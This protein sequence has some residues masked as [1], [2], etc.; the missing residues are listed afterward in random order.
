MLTTLIKKP[1]DNKGGGCYT[2]PVFPLNRFSK[3]FVESSGNF[4]ATQLGVLETTSSQFMGVGYG[5]KKEGMQMSLRNIASGRK[6]PTAGADSS[7]FS[8][9]AYLMVFAMLGF[10]PR[11][12]MAQ[13]Y[14]ALLTGVVTDPSGAVV[15]QAEVAL[16]DVSK[17][18]TITTKSDEGGRYVFAYLPP[19]G[20]RLTVKAPGFK[21]FVRE[22]IVLQVQERATIEVHLEVGAATETVEVVAA[23]ASLSLQDATTGQEVNRVFINDLPLLGRSVY[24][25]A[26]LAPGVTDVVQPYHGGTG[27]AINFISNGS[28]NSTADVLL[29]GVSTTGN[30]QSTGAQSALYTPSVDAV[31][32]FKVQQSNFSADIG[33]SGAT[34]INMLMRSGTNQFHGSAYEY[35]RN[36]VLTGNDWFRNANNV[37]I[38]ARRYNLFGF[39]IGGPIRKDRTFFF[40]DYEGKRDLA[41]KTFRAGVPSAAMRTGDFAEICGAGF[42]ANGMCLDEE[43]QLWDPYSGVYDPDEGGPVR[44]LPIPYNNL[45]TYQSPGNPN[46]DGT[47]YQLAPQPG[48]LIDPVASRMM[49]GYPLPNIGVGSADY[50]RFNN[51]IGS[52]SSRYS[53]NQWDL[54][55]D[56]SFRAQDRLSA[57]YSELRNKGL[58]AKCWDNATD[59]CSGGHEYDTTRMFSLNFTHTFNST[60]LLS[61][62]LGIARTFNFV[63]S[64]VEDYPPEDTDVVALRMPEYTLRSGVRALPNIWPADYG[65]AGPVGCLGTQA[66]SVFRNGQETHHL[67]AS[68]VR[69]QGRHELKIGGEGRMHRINLLIPEGGA[70]VYSYYFNSTSQYPWWGGGDAM[71]SFLTGV[72]TPGSWG[73]YQVPVIPATQNF[74]YAGYFQDNWKVTKRLTLNLGMRYDLETSRTERHNRGSYFDPEVSSPLQVPGLTGLRGGLRFADNQ[75]RTIYDNDRNNWGPRFGLAYRLADNLVFRGGYGLFYSISRRGT[76]GPDSIGWQ[77][78]KETSDWITSFQGDGATPWGRLSDPW[79]VTGPSLPPGSSEGLLSYVGRGITAP[80]RTIVATPYEQTWS[81]GIQQSLPGNILIDANYVGKKGTKL[82]FSGAGGL[83]HLGPELTSLP[84]DEISALNEYV[85][86][87]FFGII[88]NPLSPL[89]GPT[90][91]AYQLQLPFPQFTGVSADSPPVAN[92]IYHAFQLRVERRFAKGFQL[93]ATYSNG[94]SIDDS[95]VASGDVV[96]LGGGRTSLQDPNRRFLERSLSFFDIS[97]ILQLAYV[98][99]LPIGRGKAVGT[100]WNPWLNGFLGGWKTN[101]IWRF[102]SG[103]P[104]SLTLSGGQNLPTYGDQRPNLTAPLRRSTGADFVDQYFANP[105]VAVVPPPF[106][107]GLA[108]RTIS[109]VRAPG[110]NMATLSLFKEIPL[111]GVREGMR[112]EYRVEAFNAFNRPHFCGPDDVVEGGSFG[113]ITSICQTPREFQ[114][115]LKLYW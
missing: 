86:N 7:Y 115:A 6:C 50:D 5:I 39:T 84:L 89:S 104:I 11:T 27:G 79:P 13:L 63:P 73:E 97:Q 90:V 92:S 43:G 41:A 85:P 17:G 52:G 98:Y 70:G 114:M 48:N 4:P 80:I 10:S 21:S 103:P 55:I 14:S 30:E 65:C 93:L 15:P 54:K 3:H 44:S 53:T 61:V 78:Y 16:V 19:S 45:A 76:A 9:L 46:L 105:E 88:T 35:L 94:K 95:S 107:L 12:A 110:I 99:E 56:H 112:L 49:Q 20:Y 37:P 51:W 38:P 69:V 66:W 25:L 71:A 96:Y 1:L 81:I 67:A 24:D 91:Q 33:F 113:K 22:D 64:N 102:S 57:R 60:N 109:S 26:R 42:D 59:P 82:Y 28:R 101:G 77:G 34:V 87:P 106:T 75:T 2:A 72:G 31:Q 23:P 108:P 36:D 18:T 8:W 68:I 74:K 32:E 62:S 58:R 29:D 47:G 40:F 100:N 83:N 111:S